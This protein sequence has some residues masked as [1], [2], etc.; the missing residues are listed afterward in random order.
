MNPQ[1][2]KL[3]T[4]ADYVQWDG[5]WELIDGKAYNTSPSPTW[6]H[7]FAVMELSFAFRSHFQN[8]NCYVAIAPFD[9]RLSES[10]D[11]TYA[12]HVVQPDISVI[13]NKNSL[14]TNGCLGAPT[15]IVEVLSPSTAL[16]DRNEKFKLY[17]QFN[18]QEYWIVDPLYRTVEVFGLEDGFFKKREAFGENDTIT[19]FIFTNFSLEAKQ[20]FFQ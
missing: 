18:V 17:E 20:L 12:K 2:S 11:Y 5:R 13:C 16:K 19:S 7:Q 10:D 6:E 1:S 8:K 9:V 14:T 3:Y 15:L 4:Y